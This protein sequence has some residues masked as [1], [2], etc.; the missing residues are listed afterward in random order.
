MKLKS[1]QISQLNAAAS[2]LFF[3]SVLT[4]NVAMAQ[5]QAANASTNEL[6]KTCY[7][8]SSAFSPIGLSWDGDYSR[9]SELDDLSQA[10]RL[11]SLA[12]HQDC[13]RQAQAIKAD[14]LSASIRESLEVFIHSTKLDIEADQW[15]KYEYPSN[16]ISGWD[17]GVFQVLTSAHPLRNEQDAVAYV[18]RAKQLAR[19]L[20]QVRQHINQSEAVGVILPKPLYQAVFDNFKPLLKT[21]NQHPLMQDF[22]QKLKKLTSAKPALISD[23]TAKKLSAQ[24]AQQISTSILP[25]LRSQLSFLKEQQKRAPEKGGISS[26]A[27][28]VDAYNF[29][30]RR[31]TTTQLNAQQVHELGLQTVA[32]LEGQMSVALKAAGLPSQ[33]NERAKTF[34]QL[35][36][37]AQFHYPNTEAG[38]KLMLAEAN[39]YVQQMREALPKLFGRL[40][41]ADVI[42]E[43]MPS[44]AE[45]GDAAARYQSPARDGSQP[46]KFVL[47]MAD[48]WRVPRYTME[49]LAY[50]E[51]IPGHHLQ[52][53]IAQES[54]ELPQFRQH[55]WY[56]AYGEGWALYSEQLGK[57]VGL[58][59]TP[60]SEV[61][62]LSE[63]MWRACRLVV[64][65]GLH[66][67]NWTRE[68]AVQYMLKHIP[69]QR[70]EVQSEVDRYLVWPGQATGYMIGKLRIEALRAKAKQ[71]MGERFDV[72]DFHDVVLGA[73][74]VPLDVLESIV[75][76]WAQSKI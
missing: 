48:T 16:P 75:T 53:A 73:G 63:Q 20:G 26:I 42:V 28:G 17:T 7:E 74:P 57:E 64:D 40:P 50:H 54:T 31:Q 56:V 6:F 71:I 5:S 25:A 22:S 14:D 60:L 76:R 44:F 43:R 69:T 55:L 12:V 66:S 67:L 45:A 39:A 21:G 9:N 8:K 46:G 51:A 11:A 70:A 18:A 47:N 3:A 4:V 36:T 61:G 58:Y 2:V 30:L 15:R 62:R 10:T 19:Y 72:R 49:A 35:R 37:G 24:L 68:Q 33:E 23:A 59:R 13:L 29:Y 52:N 65:T 1:K 41:K 38:R 32:Q 27:G 34:Q